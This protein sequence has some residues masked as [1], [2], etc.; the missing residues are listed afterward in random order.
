MYKCSFE[1]KSQKQ[2]IIVSNCVSDP[3]R[4]RSIF[5]LGPTVDPISAFGIRIRIP[6]P[7][8]LKSSFKSPNLL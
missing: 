5:N 1:I 8:D 2:Q 6:D 3:D 4:V 7:D